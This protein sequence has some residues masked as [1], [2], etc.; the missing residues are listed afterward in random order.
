MKNQTAQSARPLF[1]KLNFIVGG[2][3]IVLIIAGYLL[4]TGGRQDGPVFNAA[5]IYSERRITVA[6]IVILLGFIVTIVAIFL[7]PKQE[8]HEI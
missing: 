8:T 5:E 4:M 3:G 1:G 2:I 6:P 7:K